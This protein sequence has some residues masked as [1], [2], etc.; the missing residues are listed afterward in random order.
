[1]DCIIVNLPAIRAAITATLDEDGISPLQQFIDGRR[2]PIRYEGDNPV[3]ATKSA[4]FVRDAEEFKMLVLLY[5][6]VIVRVFNPRDLTGYQIPDVDP[7][8]GE[9]LW[10]E[11]VDE[12]GGRRMVRRMKDVPSDQELLAE[13]RAVY[14]YTLTD[15]VVVGEGPETEQRPRPLIFGRIAN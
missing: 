5:S 13:Y 15:T 7:E 14:D 1:M 10:D 12:E 8:T 3:T 11:V 6:D 2:T 9:Q 4:A